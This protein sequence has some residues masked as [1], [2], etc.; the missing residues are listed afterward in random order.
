MQI[1]NPILTVAVAVILASI[2]YSGILLK[3]SLDIVRNSKSSIEIQKINAQ[4]LSTALG[5]I[6]LNI[7]RYIISRN[8]SSQD[9]LDRY[10]KEFKAESDTLYL[11]SRNLSGLKNWGDTIHNNFPNII[12]DVEAR[13]KLLPPKLTQHN[14]VDLFQDNGNPFSDIW[15]AIDHLRS[16]QIKSIKASTNETI[17]AGSHSWKVNVFGSTF[18]LLVILGGYVYT[19]NIYKKRNL[20]EAK[21]ILSE[22][23]R[24]ENEK[25]LQAVIDNCTSIIYIK[26]KNSRFTLINQ[27]F[28]TVFHLEN[29]AIIGRTHKEIFENKIQ[30][31]DDSAEDRILKFGE[32]QDANQSVNVKGRIYHFLTSK[33]PLYNT[34]GEILGLGAVCTDITMQ[35]EHEN[36][37]TVAREL[38]EAGKVS[39]QRFLA[40]M[41]HEI[42]TPMNGVIGMTNL[43]DSTKLNPEQRDYVNVIRQ[44]SNILMLL[45]NDI[46]DVSKMQAGMLK[47]EKIPFELRDSIRQIFLSY[48]PVADEMDTILTCDVEPSI[49]EF[50]LGDP[51]RLNQII[52]NLV[53][54]AIKFTSSGSVNIKVAATEKEN[55][56]YNL[57][58][59][60]IDT[61]IGIPENKLQDVFKSFTQSSTSTTRKYGGTG[62]GLAIVKELV[63][64][65]NGEVLLSSKLNYGSTFTVI[66][67]FPIA[68]VDKTVQHKTQNG[69][70]FASLKNKRI[71]VVEDNL[72]NQKVARQILLKAGVDVV[73]VAENG[74]RALEILEK[75][76]YDAVLMDVQMPEMDGMETTRHIRKNL[77]LSVPIIA[78]TASALPEDREIC[79]DAGMNE[80]V[81]KPFLPEDLL[82]KL[83]LLLQ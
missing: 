58:V 1:R 4:E 35:I 60:V 23:K 2:I 38:A 51:L 80:Y 10:I 56:I 20:A 73:D 64:M 75:D 52:S 48:K 19:R 37:L 17:A 33:F 68:A 40:N 67:P 11:V 49:P 41:S 83:S 32:I 82:Q 43:L 74:F 69:Q 57:R 6:Q 16:Y 18:M 22:A 81:T 61:G 29:E 66:I 21:E 78:L 8:K 39:Q 47:L 26:D 59:D 9:S 54:N 25:L 55:G 77:E 63:E 71:L 3:N 7:N 36:E 76:T 79:I 28:R 42:R 53:N 46:L 65:Q 14:A 34:N 50:L 27:V 13:I 12:K 31:F 72:I 62:L 5:N 24:K 45:I 70:Q 44:S 15:I 30:N